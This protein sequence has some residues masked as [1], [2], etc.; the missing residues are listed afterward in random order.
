M[1]ELRKFASKQQM[2]RTHQQ[3]VN[4]FPIVYAFN[5]QDLYAG[6]KK[7]WNI[8]L[9]TAKERPK[10]CSIGAGGY[11]LLKDK[12]DL[13]A[14]FKKQDEERKLFATD[15]NQLVTVIRSAMFSHEYSY[16]LDKDDVMEELSSYADNPRFEEAWKK[17][18]KAVLKKTA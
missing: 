3:E 7:V 14:L 18:E 17:A 2:E 5:E 8:D 13:I 15:F 10:L 4:D 9:K 16:T 1:S 12:A 11:I 6:A